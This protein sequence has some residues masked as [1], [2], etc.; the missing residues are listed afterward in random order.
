MSGLNQE[1]LA[2]LDF[3]VLAI[4]RTD[5]GRWWNFK[6][7]ISPFS[8]L[9][10]VLAGRAVVR[11]HG[12]QFF[13][14]PGCMHLVPP[15]TAHD[16]SCSRRLDHYHLHF[17]S[18][19]PTGVDLFSLLDCPFQLPVSAETRKYFH[20]L[21]A[22]YPDRKLPCYDPAREEYRSFPVAAERDSHSL[23][24][25]SW[26]ET[27]GLLTLLLT[28]FIQT[29]QVHEGIHAR[30][31]RQFLAVQ[32]YIHRHIREPILLGDLARAAKLH[33]TYFSDRFQKLVGIRPLEYLMRYRLERAQFLLLT[34]RA[35]VKQVAYEVGIPDPA[36]F[37]RVFSR[38]WQVSPTQ[39]RADHAA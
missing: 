11:H 31:T 4:Q 38:F 12:Q 27:N 20:R 19:L 30:V 16:C 8:R 24:M 5:A 14:E 37:T 3:K 39:Y 35:P 34:S 2:G 28:P 9:W 18:R 33:P 25:A 17:L 13:L 6:N 36:Y 32:E 22:L 23:S 21:E 29:A 26:F 1:L 15:F 10:L 7:V